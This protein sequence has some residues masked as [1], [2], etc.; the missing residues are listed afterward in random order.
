MIM[1]DFTDNV[2]KNVLLFQTHWLKLSRVLKP[3]VMQFL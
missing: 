1:L 2:A 3:L